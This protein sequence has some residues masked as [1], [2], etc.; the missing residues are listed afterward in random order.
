MAEILGKAIVFR[1]DI[2]PTEISVG[3]RY[4]PIEDPV[5]GTKTDLWAVF[6]A[7]NLD[8]GAGY[9]S[10]Y[11]TEASFEA[12]LDYA[13]SRIGLSLATDRH[14][15]SCFSSCYDCL[16]HYGNRFSHCQLDWRLGIDLLAI[17]NGNEPTLA[18]KENHWSAVVNTRIKRRLEEFGFQNVKMDRVGDYS[19]ARINQTTTYRNSASQPAH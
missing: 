17:L 11:S 13:S 19:V 12:L 9:S 7:D 4:E 5:F 14:S 18:M 15:H 16:R 6:I 3:I 1:E 8:N 2:E 10:N